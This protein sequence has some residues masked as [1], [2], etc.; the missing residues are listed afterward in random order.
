MCQVQKWHTWLPLLFRLWKLTHMVWKSWRCAFQISLQHRS[1]WKECSELTV[2]S[3]STF[4]IYHNSKAM[5]RLSPYSSQPITEHNNGLDISDQCK[6]YWWASFVLE[7]NIG[8]VKT[9]S[10]LCCSLKFSLL[11]HP[12][13]PSLFTRVR[14]TLWFEGSPCLL[15]LPLR[16]VV[17]RAHPQ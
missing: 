7:L 4:R 12:S 8:L 15:L 14:T 11:G 2:S 6:I 9:F 5:A 3:C 13:F 17:H 10:E 16:S 1:C